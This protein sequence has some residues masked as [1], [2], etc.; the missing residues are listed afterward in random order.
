LQIYLVLLILC[1]VKAKLIEE[2]DNEIMFIQY[3]IIGYWEIERI[4]YYSLNKKIA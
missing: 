1:I 2:D 4:C 3:L